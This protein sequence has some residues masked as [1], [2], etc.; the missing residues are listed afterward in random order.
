[1]CLRHLDNDLITGI[2]P[3]RTHFADLPF[4]GEEEQEVYM[5]SD[6]TPSEDL[7]RH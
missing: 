5:T 2:T 6:L 7:E 4:A 3:L 1:M